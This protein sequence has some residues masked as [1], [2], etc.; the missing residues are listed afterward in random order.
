FYAA[1]DLPGVDPDSIDCTVERNVLTARHG[2]R[3]IPAFTSG[4]YA[5]HWFEKALAGRVDDAAQAR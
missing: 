3:E 4:P 2:Y 5:Q 1:F